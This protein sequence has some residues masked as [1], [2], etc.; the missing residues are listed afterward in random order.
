MQNFWDSVLVNGEE[1]E[2]E[3]TI[4][5]NELVAIIVGED[6]YFYHPELGDIDGVSHE[7]SRAAVGYFL[8]G[9]EEPVGSSK[10]I[11][12]ET[13]QS[14]T[15]LEIVH[16]GYDTYLF[17]NKRKRY[18]A[19][20]D[21]YE[22][23]PHILKPRG[24]II[25]IYLLGALLSLSPLFSSL[26]V[27]EERVPMSHTPIRL[28][29]STFK[30]WAFLPGATATLGVISPD[31][32]ERMKLSWEKDPETAATINA[33]EALGVVTQVITTLTGAWAGDLLG[34]ITSE[35]I[36]EVLDVFQSLTPAFFESGE[37][38]DSFRSRLDDVYDRYLFSH[39]RL[40][41]RDSAKA[42]TTTAV[43]MAV[44]KAISMIN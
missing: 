30:L 7:T 5:L 27:D 4:E 40:L 35:F 19:V 43:A 18:A 32:R 13:I 39:W 2:N 36:G 28:Y 1:H 25:E 31:F 34:D 6:I 41:T 26:E 9:Q 21:S 16:E 20:T 17:R 22:Q 33:L 3:A 24:G 42:I 15:G 12:G 23:H 44:I 11:T 10:T 37:G 8:F 38:G 14:A 29:G